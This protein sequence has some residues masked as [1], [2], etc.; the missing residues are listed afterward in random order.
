M[1]K[2]DFGMIDWTDAQLDEMFLR[3]EA[4]PL[5][6]FVNANAHDADLSSHEIHNDRQ[7]KGFMPRGLPA[8][9]ATARL[10]LGFAKRLWTSKGGFGGETRYFGGTIATKHSVRDITLDRQTHD[11]PPGRYILLGYT[12]PVFEH[13]FYDL[14][15]P[16]SDDLMLFRGYTGQFPD[17]KRGWT[18]MLLRRYPFSQMGIDDYDLF[19]AG[20]P[21]TDI[22]LVGTWRLDALYYSNQPV[23]IAQLR[24]DRA[25]DGQLHIDCDTSNGRHGLLLPKFV[26][27]H[28]QTGAL[29]AL[30]K[31]MRAVDAQ[32]VV[33]KWTTDIRGPYAKF[34]LAGAPGL[35]HREKG[36]GR[37]P[38][39]SLYY[40][41]TRIAPA[42]TAG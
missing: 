38:R 34:L 6:D 2:P 42:P 26:S 29:P 35:F 40:L 19:A 36:T 28:F 9:E 1:P 13:L 27:E 30:R 21:P 18:A 5:D 33:G 15:K 23:H 24:F 31:E 12:D 3:S 25:A 14:L 11:L 10:S 22:D 37:T 4:R 20:S 16:I 8:T 32:Y 17:G 39:F 41:L 7:W